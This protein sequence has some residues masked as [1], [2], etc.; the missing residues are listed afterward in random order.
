M[1]ER[2]RS[3]RG[4]AIVELALILPFILLFILGI[5]EFG[6]LF[7][8]KAMVTNASR[9]GARTAMTYKKPSGIYWSED[10]AE[11]AAR[12]A[13]I[14]YL[15]ARLINFGGGAINDVVSVV[16]DRTGW[17]PGDPDH[18]EYNVSGGTVDVTV[19]Y[20]HTFLVF[21]RIAGWGNTINLGAQTIMRLE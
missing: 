8:D 7:Y 19:T 6:I 9:E 10:A 20:T 13:V 16:A 2:L 17:S 12:T 1:I 4:Q 11:A 3:D 14:N 15:S 18:T 21:P 5:I